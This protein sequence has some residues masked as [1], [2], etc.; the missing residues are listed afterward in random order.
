[1]LIFYRIKFVV[2]TK[3]CSSSSRK[4]CK[5]KKNKVPGFD[6]VDIKIVVCGNSICYPSKNLA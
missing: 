1:M 5:S 6:T 4:K 3:K 2:Y